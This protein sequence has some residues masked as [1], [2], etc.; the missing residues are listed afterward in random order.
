M[1]ISAFIF[2]AVIF[3]PSLARAQLKETCLSITGSTLTYTYSGGRISASGRASPAESERALRVALFYRWLERE[4]FFLSP[5]ADLGGLREAAAGLGRAEESVFSALGI[6]DVL[7]PVKFLQAYADASASFDLF[8]FSPSEQGAGAVLLAVEAGVRG[9]GETAG[10]LAASVQE[11]FDLTGADVLAFIGGESATDRKTVLGDL[12]L[13]KKNS[14]MAAERLAELR[15]CLEVSSSYCRVSWPDMRFREGAAAPVSSSSIISPAGLGLA[16]REL[17]GPYLVETS[18]WGGNKSNFLYAWELSFPDQ[19]VP[20]EWDILA[21][22]MYFRRMTPAFKSSKITAQG[23]KLLPVDATAP[24]DCNDLE[25]KP[26]VRVLDYF[27]S[28]Y[29]SAPA[30]VGAL[31]S[32]DQAAAL[33]SMRVAEETFFFARYKSQNGLERLGLAYFKAYK[34]F[35]SSGRDEEWSR[36][37][38]ARARLIALKTQDLGAI[39]GRLAFHTGNYARRLSRTPPLGPAVRRLNAAL[40]TKTYYS[41]TFMP[42]SP[43]V[44]LLPERPG[45]LAKSGG[46]RNEDFLNYSRAL[47]EYGQEEVVRDAGFYYENGGRGEALD[48]AGL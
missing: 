35:Q 47:R 37:L 26:V 40:L 45:Y 34:A 30:P 4:P 11:S 2:F 9:Y 23:L 12:A 16:G 1:R 29:S 27:V 8:A 14:A 42:F 33:K 20:M 5:G 10:A 38:L 28:H 13:I 46:A 18:C 44:W 6:K 36:A 32:A 21:T 43:S 19:P 22:D 25:Y 17:R 39:I 31:L 15:K 48:P 3:L 41:V 24:Y 7:Y